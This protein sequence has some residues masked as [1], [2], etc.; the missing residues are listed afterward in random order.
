MAVDRIYAYRQTHTLTRVLCSE[1][2]TYCVR[3]ISYLYSTTCLFKST[4]V[5]QNGRLR[6]KAHDKILLVNDSAVCSSS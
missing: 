2:N 4:V 3:V 6:V 1:R 5:T